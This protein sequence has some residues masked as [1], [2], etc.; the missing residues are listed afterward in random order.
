MTLPLSGDRMLLV[1]SLRNYHRELVALLLVAGSIL[2]A[3]GNADAATYT[4][5]PHTNGEAGVSIQSVP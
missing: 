3:A 5:A 2:V 4:T 1:T